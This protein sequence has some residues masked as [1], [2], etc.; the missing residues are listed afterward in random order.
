MSTRRKRKEVETMETMETMTTEEVT[1]EVTDEVIKAAPDDPFETIVNKMRDSLHF[2]LDNAQAIVSVE[3]KDGTTVDIIKKVYQFVEPVGNK[4]QLT[5]M[6]EKT[7]KSIETI[8]GAYNVN[9]M[10]TYIICKEFSKLNDKDNLEKMGFKTVGEFG[11]ALFG[12]ETSTVN[13]YARIGE[14][15]ITDDYQVNPMLPQLSVSHLLELTSYSDGDVEKISELYQNGTLV[16]GMSTKKI[17]E[18]LKSLRE[19]AIEDKQKSTD[20]NTDNGTIVTDNGTEVITDSK[21]EESKSDASE[22]S[23]DTIENLQANFD[24]QVI[25]GKMLNFCEVMERLFIMLKE[26]DIEI[27]DYSTPINT[28]KAMIQTIL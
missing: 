9:K 15:F 21:K 13:H 27:V 12:L 23:T 2:D 14:L 26:H 10:S 1:E 8:Q 11:K 22:P 25:A 28:I 20:E 16:D 5:V 19:S 7:I 3:K 4:T 18:T 6:D 24:K 17:R